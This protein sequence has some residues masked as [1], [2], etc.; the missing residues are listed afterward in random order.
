MPPR[1]T[2]QRQKMKKN[3][4]KTGKAL[5]K[6]KKQLIIGKVYANWCGHCQSLK[7]EWNRMEQDI[8]QLPRMNHVIFMK[9]EEGEKDKLANFNAQHAGLQ[10]SG[11][12]TIFSYNG[13]GFN[14]YKGS[15]D[16]D[17]LKRWVIGG[18]K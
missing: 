1:K 15:R 17:S 13:K 18:G 6:I 4:H 16:A 7:P 12:P 2:R 5:P 10:V 8:Q 3:A 11:Y 9:F 14:Y